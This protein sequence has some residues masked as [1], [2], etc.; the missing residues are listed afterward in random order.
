MGLF[1]KVSNIQNKSER[2]R[3]IFLWMTTI[4]IFGVI[5]IIWTSTLDLTPS[6]D[7]SVSVT[8]AYEELSPFATVK[9]AF[10]GFFSDVKR[11]YDTFLDGIRGDTGENAVMREE[12]SNTDKNVQ[13]IPPSDPPP[14]QSG[15]VSPGVLFNNTQNELQGAVGGTDEALPGGVG[16]TSIGDGIE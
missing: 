4:L 16:T 11:G 13:T 14:S 12:D 2:E 9:R 5:V 7:D 15:S 6:D 8:G 1:E 10:G 3:R